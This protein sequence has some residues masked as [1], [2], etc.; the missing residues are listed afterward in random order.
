MR[1]T[2]LG[3]NFRKLVRDSNGSG[4]KSTWANKKTVDETGLP[5]E[6]EL[7]YELTT[8]EFR[9]S[10]LDWARSGLGWH[11]SVGLGRAWATRTRPRLVRRALGCWPD[12]VSFAGAAIGRRGKGKGEENEREK[13]KKKRKKKEKR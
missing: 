9:L 4:Y 10:D 12:A 5:R 1:A 7:A 8:K 3:I 6:M 11:P 2:D 13:E